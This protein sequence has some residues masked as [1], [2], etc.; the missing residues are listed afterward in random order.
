MNMTNELA[1]NRNS[2]ACDQIKELCGELF[3]NTPISWF[4]YARFYRNREFMLAMSDSKVQEFFLSNNYHIAE[5]GHRKYDDLPNG[6]FFANL[7]T[8]T[9]AEV[10]MHLEIKRR[11]G[12]DNFVGVFRKNDNYCDIYNFAADIKHSDLPNFYL[13]NIYLLEK[14]I[15][16][17]ENP[18]KKILHSNS[19]SRILIPETVVDTDFN[20]TDHRIHNFSDIVANTI[21]ADELDDSPIA[22]RS[23]L[24]LG[25][26]TQREL[27]CVRYIVR[28]YT[29]KE[30]AKEL[31]LSFRTVEN[32]CERIKTKLGCRRKQDIIVR[33]SGAF[34]IGSNSEIL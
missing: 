34:D 14:Y 27:D 16:I 23:D 24:V 8:S 15:D 31:S 21:S 7:L 30:I 2:T 10:E 29:S 17:F 26:L 13:N 19:V 5:F 22:K 9:E 6:S 28:G 12:L 25:R 18:M 4:G 3:R 1:L 20:V 33:Y 11:F 32:Y